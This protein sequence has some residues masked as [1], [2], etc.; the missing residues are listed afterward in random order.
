VSRNRAYEVV[1]RR[2]RASLLVTAVLAL[3]V[4]PGAA[5]ARTAFVAKGDNTQAVVAVNLATGTTADIAVGYSPQAVAIT[6]D[7]VTAYVANYGSHSLTPIDV[8]T[9]VAGDEIDLGLGHYAHGIAISPDGT[10]AYVTTDNFD[11]DYAQL[12]GVVRPVTLATGAVGPAIT[13]GNGAEG[14]AFSPDGTKALVS[15]STDHTV[16]PI[17]VA[18]G[19]AG[20]PIPVPNA[21]HGIAFTPDGASAYVGTDSS[22]VPIDA[23]ANTAGSA[24]ST[25]GVQ[26]IAV[27]PNGG[28][29]LAGTVSG[30]TPLTIGSGGATAGTPIACSQCRPSDVAYAPGGAM[31]YYTASLNYTDG[32]F[33]P[34]NVAAGTL[35]TPIAI[36]GMPLG[37]AIVP[38]QAPVASLSVT[39]GA[40]GTAT[41]FDA[42]ASTD[43]DGSIAGYE[44]DFG[45]GTTATTGQPTTSHTYAAYGTYPAAVTLTDDEGCSTQFQFTGQTATCNGKPTARAASSV[46]IRQDEVNVSLAGTGSG[47]VIDYSGQINCG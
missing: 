23:A 2:A 34:V 24:I 13:T 47:T 37:F 12:P 36:G 41:T 33:T 35:G 29:A 15:N 1:A 9:G 7:G 27:A 25:N 18:T 43:A 30:L 14:V 21:P 3:G 17:T 8:A 11:P 6:P 39:A 4:A 42:S 32:T 16:T 28:K 40:P 38:D 45:D 10:T 46:G 5:S 19:T 31:A 26:G 44:W 20:T 22:V